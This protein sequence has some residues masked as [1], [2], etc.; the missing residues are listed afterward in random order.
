MKKRNG[1]TLIELLVVIAIIAVLTSLLLPA[2]QQ[3]REAARRTQCKNNMKQLALAIHNYE[4]SNSVLPPSRLTPDVEIYDNIGNYSGYQ[5]WTTMILPYI[6]QGNL[7]NT[8]DFNYAWSSAQNRPAISRKV[9]TFV[10]PSVPGDNRADPQWVKG[11]YGGDYNSV[12]EIKPKVY[13]SVLNLPDPGD[14]SRAGVLAKGSKNTFAHVTDGTSNT[15]MLAEVAGQPDIWT[16]EGRMNATRFAAYSDDKVVDLGGRY[17]ASDGTGWADPDNG[18]SINGA[19]QNGL[20]KYGPYMINR[21]NTSEVFS[22]H[23]GMAIVA[24]AD[25]SVKSV[26]DSVDTLLFVGACTRSGGEVPGEF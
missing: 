11:A 15:I 12:N 4:S 21:I 8:L 3:A 17:V 10:C 6:D 2:V 24:M 13:T 23:T 7:Q 14:A 25:G 1:F 19:T 22:F 18:F 9:V 16:S 20:D 5:S 26:S